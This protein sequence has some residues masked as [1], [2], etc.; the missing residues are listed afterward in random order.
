MYYVLYDGLFTFV[1]SV[2]PIQEFPLNLPLIKLLATLSGTVART[3]Q[4]RA[5]QALA[6]CKK[7]EKTLLHSFVYYTTWFNQECQILRSLAYF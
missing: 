7:H 4:P 3:A 5:L 6:A 1:W 2:A